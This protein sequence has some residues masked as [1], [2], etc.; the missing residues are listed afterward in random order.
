MSATHRNR[1]FSAE[2][3]GQKK[4]LED[5]P[6]RVDTNLIMHDVVAAANSLSVCVEVIAYKH[7]PREPCL[8]RI[9]ITVS[10]DPHL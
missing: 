7:P 5:Y 3:R 2:M 1:A 8:N 9:G 10:R 6:E 4:R